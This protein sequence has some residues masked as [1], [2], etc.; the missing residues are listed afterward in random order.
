M[1]GD[2]E[3]AQSFGTWL[4]RRRREL[5][6]TQDALAE[7]AGCST[8]MLRKIEA[9]SARPSRQLAE[10]IVIRLD[11]PAAQQ[12]NLVQWARGG[13]LETQTAPSP[14]STATGQELGQA[15]GSSN[16]D[17]AAVSQQLQNPYKGLRPFDETDAAD[18][19]GR[20]GLT[21]RLISRLDES[22]EMGG[23]LAVVGPSGS[24]KSS[25]VR[26]GLVPALRQGSLPGSSNWTVLDVIP[27]SHPFEEVEAALLRQAVNP[28]ASLLPQLMEDERGL[29]RAVKRVLPGNGDAAMLLVLDQFE[30]V[31]TLVDDEAM[32]KRFLDGLFTAA[33]DPR[34][35]LHVVATLRAD[36]YD[37]PLLYRQPGEIMRQRTEVVL[38]MSGDELERAIVRPAARVGVRLEQD[39]LAAIIQDVT[40][41]PGALPLMQYALTELFERRVGMI[42]TL[43]AYRESGGVPGALSRRAEALYGQLSPIEH[44]ATRQLFLRLVTPGEGVEDTRRRVRIAELATAA[45]D[46]EAL[47]RVLDLFGRYRLLTFDRDPVTGG[48]TVE[49]AHEALITSWGRLR[50]WLDTSR[51]SLRVQ[52]RLLSA[53]TEWTAA[54]EDSSFLAHGVRLAQFE[55]LDAEGDVAL[56]AQERTYLQ[57]SV[58]EREARETEERDRQA[59]EVA[60]QR[61]AAVRLRY[62]AGALAIF[63]LVAVG[64][65]L[66]AYSQS[67]QAQ[68]NATQAQANAAQAQTNADQAQANQKQ[69]DAERQ[70]A[71]A[72]LTQ[73]EALRLAAEAN[74]L[75]QSK[76]APELAALLSIRSALTQPSSQGDAVLEAAATLG[77]PIRQFVGHTDL[78]NDVA[79]SPDGKQVLTGSLDKTAR[80]WDAATGALIRTF[81]GH[82]RGVRAV[83]F[84]PDGKYVLTG[85]GDST[86]RLWDTASGKGVLTFTGHTDGIN[87]VVFSPDGKRIASASDDGTAR[88]WDAATGKALLQ[89]T[90]HDGPVI[91]VAFSP[92]GK[93][94]LTGSLDKSAQLWD[95]G[96]GQVLQRFLG[97][98]DFVLGVAF[99]PDGKT[100]ATGSED[101]TTRLW[102]IA[103]GKELQRFKGDTDFVHAVAFSP[104]G[105]TLLTSSGDRTAR[106]WDIATGQ[107][108][109]RF[110]GHSDRIDGAAFSP[111]GSEVLTG[112]GDGTARLWSIGEQRA[113]PQFTA[114][115]DP[116]V[117]AAFSPDGKRIL[118]GGERPDT[119]ARMWDA[120]TGK[121]LFTLAGMT[122]NVNAVAFSPDG[123]L[124]LTGS[125]VPD[126]TARMWD[127]A[128]GKPL[129]TITGTN[130]PVYAGV[131]SP[132]GAAVLTAHADGA[133]RLWDSHTGTLLKSFSVPKSRV[134]AVA[135]S[136]DGKL[137]ATGND[138]I[139]TLWDAG[140]G[141][142]IGSFD[143][144]VDVVQTV[145]FSPDGKSLLTGNSDGTVRLWDIATGQEIRRYAGHDAFIDS[146]AF[147]PDGKLVAAG[148]D[149]NTAS[150]WDASSGNEL[151]RLTG[152][153]GVVQTVAFS[154]DGKTVV[155]ASGDGTARLWYVDRRDTIN[156]LC[157]RLPRDFSDQERAQYNIPDKNPT[158]PG[159]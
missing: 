154:P 19:F 140:T 124:L 3:A 141:Q 2:A 136:R 41:Q 86:M 75:M 111:D 22:D 9:G 72:N 155:T 104:D 37:R 149:D 25:V 120:Q 91:D 32:R 84:S 7:Q 47:H 40:E 102:D 23:F 66:L 50:E 64:L 129:F 38:P 144:K 99:S 8:E 107:E 61:R 95:A 157:S 39:L 4:K 138:G 77:Y 27:G 51:E 158:C 96:T 126:N 30:E 133:A 52:R 53:A 57:A 123:K 69:A 24:G 65:G 71:V 87:A 100:V 119:T 156:Y 113:L 159:K 134:N 110:I 137:I 12:P 45:P 152:H 147:S 67:Q 78:V 68:S 82:T 103:T 18:F 81:A 20:E 153:N 60:T 148:S 17:A 132:D 151:R 92:D 44:E 49:V 114:T 11:V 83:A 34:S 109:R 29:L 28:P 98:T 55:A 90:G 15:P 88:I 101:H 70:Q 6:L 125:G 13:R 105:K 54:Q 128:T 56:N 43:Q 127:A 121:E 5:D 93:Q 48:P 115:E 21:R 73:S 143:S 31:F 42:M 74:G 106:L 16:G 139:A 1:L 85:S 36:F 46:E 118:T 58:A 76:G 97:H 131:F 26:A 35:P 89:F 130:V 62:L 142:Q 116:L 63:L 146:V 33:T 10:L 122:G 135:F 14:A 145:A 59:R 108:V 79:F 150:I 117:S 80:L 94:A 112:S